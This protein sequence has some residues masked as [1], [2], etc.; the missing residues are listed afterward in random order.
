VIEQRFIPPTNGNPVACD[1]PVRGACL[2]A[3]KFGGQ[4]AH[5]RQAVEI[6]QATGNDL[7]AALAGYRWRQDAQPSAKHIDWQFLPRTDAAALAVMS[8]ESV[9]FAGRGSG[10]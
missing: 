2:L 7:I 3:I 4:S 6:I 5:D 1:R 9:K 8:V 10:D